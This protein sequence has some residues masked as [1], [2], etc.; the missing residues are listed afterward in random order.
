MSEIRE[1]IEEI[2]GVQ[3]EDG[4]K[5]QD[6][7]LRLAEEVSEC[8]EEVFED[9]IDGVRIWYEVVA[10]VFEHNQNNSKDKKPLPDFPDA[11]EEIEE[12]EIAEQEKEVVQEPTHEEAIDKGDADDDNID[13]DTEVEKEREAQESTTKKVEKPKKKRALHTKP[14]EKALYVVMAEII[15]KHPEWEIGRVMDTLDDLG[16]SWGNSSVRTY[17]YQIHVVLGILKEQGKLK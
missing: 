11:E 4:E 8:E 14:P 16:Q 5:Y 17:S 10:D 2:F 9:F 12:P 6:Y 15:C 7:L 3:Q 1:E 13:V